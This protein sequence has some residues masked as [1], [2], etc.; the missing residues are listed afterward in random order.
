MLEVKYVISAIL[1][2]F[3]GN[4][5]IKHTFEQSCKRPIRTPP[6]MHSSTMVCSPGLVNNVFIFEGLNA[7]IFDLHFCNGCN[8]SVM[9][10]VANS[11]KTN[12]QPQL[13]NKAQQAQYYYIIINVIINY[14]LSINEPAT[15]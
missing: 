10:S 6:L 15:N 14:L 11:R 9:V 12:K 4:T 13:Q 2:A 5:K 3:S 1:V 7:V 8:A